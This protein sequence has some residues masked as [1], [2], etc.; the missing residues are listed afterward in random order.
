MNWYKLSAR[1][2][3]YQ[4]ALQVFGFPPNYQPSPDEVKKKYRSLARQSHPDMGGTN[5]AMARVSEAHEVLNSPQSPQNP[6]RSRGAYRPSPGHAAYSRPYQS[7]E[8]PPWQTDTRSSYNHVPA[9]NP[10]GSEKP[11]NFRHLNYCQKKIYEYSLQQGAVQDFQ[12]AAFDGAFFRG[13]F[14]AKTNELSLGYAG[15]VMRKWNSEGANPYPTLAVLASRKGSNSWKIIQLRG[16][17]IT[18]QN[19]VLPSED[20]PWNNRNFQEFLMKIVRGTDVYA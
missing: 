4:Q 20:A 15:E 13:T 10:D 2:M 1:L 7:Q 9:D 14:T 18:A 5:E 3:S 16:V 17:D 19:M 6:W 8:Q 11:E 12:I